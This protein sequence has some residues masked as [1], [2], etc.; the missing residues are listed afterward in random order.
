MIIPIYHIKK[1]ILTNIIAPHGIT[2]LIHASQND[3][4]P[5]LLSI[6][7]GCILVSYGLSQYAL[8]DV[9]LNILF[10]GCSVIHFSHD[11]SP[12]ILNHYAKQQQ[13]LF[14]FT[15]LFS[16]V[17]QPDLFYIY[18]IFVHVPN[19]YYY[20]RN[21]ICENLVRNFIFIFIFSLFFS[22]IGENDIIFHPILYPIYKGIITSHVIY[23]EKY[24]HNNE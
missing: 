2:D 8:S 14:C 16:F 23:Q 4:I 17:I 10:F 21:V 22:L 19:H 18:M 6:N 15:M 1:K 13:F 7:S 24:I 20:N 5:E 3:N 12:I 11:F 9:I